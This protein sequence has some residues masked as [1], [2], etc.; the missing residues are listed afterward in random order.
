MNTG[1]KIAVGCGITAVVVGIVAVVGVVGVGYWAKGKAEKAFGD[2]A[3]DQKKIEQLQE[4]AN[5]NDFTPPTDGTITEARLQKFLEARKRIFDVYK[6]HEAEI[7]AM[8][9]KKDAGIGDAMKGLG[10]INE[11][12]LARAQ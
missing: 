4:K 2:I 11:A 6:A 3:G 5:K 9:N 1:A 7:E 12:R 8:K 10:V